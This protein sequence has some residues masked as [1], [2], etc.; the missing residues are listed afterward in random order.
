MLF[1]SVLQRLN[2]Y[3][4]HNSAHCK[5]LDR[6]AHLRFRHIEL[7]THPILADLDC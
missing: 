6:I 1:L 7:Q 5:Q 3:S 4:E 2:R